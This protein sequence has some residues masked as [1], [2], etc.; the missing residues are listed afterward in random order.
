MRVVTR[1]GLKETN[2]KI[3]TDNHT[4]TECNR[5]A[6]AFVAEFG[7]VPTRPLRLPR[8]SVI[9]PVYNY[10]HEIWGAVK[11]VIEQSFVNWELV[12]VDDGS[13]DNSWSLIRRL[14]EYD[15]RIVIAKQPNRGLSAARNL[16]ISISS[17]DYVALLDP[18]DRYRKNKLHEQ[19]EFMEENPYIG[20]CYS[21]AM[22]HSGEKEFPTLCPDFDRDLLLRANIIPC[23]SVMLRRTVTEVTGPFNEAM[24]EIEDYE[25]W[26]R[27]AERFAVA[28]VPKL[29]SYDIYQHPEQKSAKARNNHPGLWAELHNEVGRW[30]AERYC[31][32]QPIVS[33]VTSNEEAMKSV[34]LQTLPN[35]ECVSNDEE[36]RGMFIAHI[37]DGWR[38]ASPHDLAQMLWCMRSTTIKVIDK[39]GRITLCRNKPISNLMPR[40]IE[41][42]DNTYSMRCKNG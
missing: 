28:R 26:V 33:I 5:R 37:T 27:V 15:D 24:P 38:F 32:P 7:D 4:V 21:N 16:G 36:C 1:E 9:L 30:G 20:M 34:K 22:L 42:A 6:A 25:Y 14:P 11:S 39:T 12:V 17:G 13:T 8:V 18:D 35:V 31:N 23:Q 40:S 10:Q 29:V 41:V 3:D 2:V 19:V